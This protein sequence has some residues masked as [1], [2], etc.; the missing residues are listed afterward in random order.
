MRRALELA[1]A[2]RSRTYPNPRVGCVL[3]APDGT[4]VAEGEHRGA[5]TP[6]AEAVA[7]AAAGD[8]ARGTT[9]V[10]TLEPCNHTG[11]TPPCAEALVAA[12]VARVVVAQT[13]PN[14]QAAG[15]ADRLRAAG[16]DVETGVLADESSDLNRAWTHAVST[17]RPFVTWKLAASLDGRSAA[18]DGSSRWITGSDARRDVHRLRAECDAV[19]VGTG[20][21]LADNPRL[22]VRDADDRPLPAD[23][24]PLRVVLGESDVPAGAAVLDDAAPSLQLRTRDPHEALATLAAREVRHVWLEGGPHV[25]GAFVAAGLVDEVVAYVAP[26]L[27]GAGTAALETDAFATIADAVRLRTTDVALLGDDVRITARPLRASHR[28]TRGADH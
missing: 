3:L 15:G 2:H 9:A 16:V 17:G 11:R 27:L 14:P 7:L 25:A 18:A 10:V 13:D 26:A 21:V 1:R 23:E 4:L 5:G 12:G 28:P 22:T 20:T 8:A 24:Q 6:H 19:L